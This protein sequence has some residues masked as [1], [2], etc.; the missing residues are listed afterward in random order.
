MLPG[1]ITT[2]LPYLNSVFDDTW[3]DHENRVLIGTGSNRR[4]AFRP[5]EI[6]VATIAEPSLTR[7][8]IRGTSW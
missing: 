3:Y 8:L 2:V 1:D 7:L 4:C 5:H 6:R